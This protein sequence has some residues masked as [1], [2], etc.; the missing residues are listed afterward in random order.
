MKATTLALLLAT[1]DG[2][3]LTAPAPCMSKALS[4]VKVDKKY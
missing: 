4:E 1:T 2:K 3:A